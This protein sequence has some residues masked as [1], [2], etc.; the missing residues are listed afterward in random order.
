MLSPTVRQRLGRDCALQQIGVS[1]IATVQSD[2]IDYPY[3]YG[4][5]FQINRLWL[6][7]VNDLHETQ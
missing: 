7:S 2:H 6:S 1:L 4:S 5:R 3:S